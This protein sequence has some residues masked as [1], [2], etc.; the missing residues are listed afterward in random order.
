MSAHSS[1]AV[2]RLRRGRAPARGYDHRTRAGNSGDVIKHIAL[3]AA[4]R[5][6]LAASARSS[7]PFVYADTFA[8]YVQNRVLDRHRRQWNP[9]IGRTLERK[10]RTMLEEGDASATWLGRY[11]PETRPSLHGG[12]YPGSCL[13]AYDEIA[14]SGRR[15]K[16]MLWDTD[17]GPIEN[18]RTFFG[19][20]AGHVVFHKSAV[21]DGVLSE[22]VKEANFVFVDPPGHDDQ[23][24]ECPTTGDLASYFALPVM[25]MWLPLV[26]QRKARR[27]KGEHQKCAKIRAIAHECRASSI[28]IRTGGAVQDFGCQLLMR[29]PDEAERDVRKAVELARVA[30]GWATLPGSSSPGIELT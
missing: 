15:P 23:K 17:S 5:G 27:V 4:L 6:V 20:D 18:L 22:R 11:L 16:L 29:L 24:G 3:I 12:M 8:A 7:T 28:A 21:R 1:E 10:V 14:A 30:W 19:K 2:P 9:G 25:L 13:V 26:G